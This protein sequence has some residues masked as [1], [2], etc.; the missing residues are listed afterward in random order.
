MQCRV[1]SK[2]NSKQGCRVLNKRKRNGQKG[3]PSG[4]GGNET[5]EKRPPVCTDLDG[6]VD[7]SAHPHARFK[8][9]DFFFCSS[10]LLPKLIPSQPDTDERG[11]SAQSRN[12]LKWAQS[13]DQKGTGLAET[14]DTLF[15]KTLV[16]IPR[17]TCQEGERHTISSVQ[18]LRIQTFNLP[19]TPSTFSNSTPSHQ[20]LRAGFRQNSSSFCAMPTAL[21]ER[22]SSLTPVRR[23]ASAILQ[24]TALFGSPARCPH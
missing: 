14:N 19:S 5:Y 21:L 7:S 20:H 10:P 2:Q 11:I 6:E 12:N 3:K 1:Q 4:S 22:F 17:L 18:T 15:A 8:L 16:H 13:H 9:R 24:M 23:R